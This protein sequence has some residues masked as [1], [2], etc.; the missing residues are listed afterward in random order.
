MTAIARGGWLLC[1]AFFAAILSSILYVDHVGPTAWLLL[2]LVAAAA[3]LSPAAG[4][5]I[6]AAATPV[7]WFLASQV[8]NASVAWPE[9]IVCAVLA[10]ASLN[11]VRGRGTKE[12]LPLSISAPAVLFGA[13]V[14]ASLVASLSLKALRLG[15]GFTDA[16]ITQLTREYFIDVRGFPGL[17]AGVL[18]LEGALLFAVSARVAAESKAGQV[19]LR[20]AAAYATA[21]ATLAAA[22]NIRRLVISAARGDSFWASLIDLADRLRFNVHYADFNAAGS[23]FAMAVLLAAALAVSAHGRRRI[24]W[25]LCALTIAV[26]LWLTSSRV[27]VLAVLLAPGAVLLLVEISRGRAR[28]MRAAAVAAAAVVLLACVVVMLPQ[29]GTQAS[30]LLSADVRLGLMQTGARMLASRPMFGIGLGEFSRRSGEFSSPDLIAKFPVAWNENAH[31]NYLQ[32]AAEIGLAGGILFACLIA[33]ALAVV[34]GRALVTRDEFLLLTL[35]AVGA[36]ALT[37]LG[38]HPLLIPEAGYAFWT[39]LGVAAGATAPLAPTR[40][41]RWW[42]IPAGLVAVALTLPWQLR[43]TTQ[44]ADLEHVAI[45]VSEHWQT[46]PDDRRYREATGHAALFVPAGPSKFEIYPV[47]DE[48][49][50]LELTLDGRAADILRLEP[51]RWN[52]VTLPVRAGP[53]SGRYRR[54]DLRLIDAD[55]TT[56]WITKVRPIQ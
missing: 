15:P 39:M 22:L 27:A 19:F 4:V 35:A 44:N 40:P 48:P 52:D 12:W 5:L 38:G 47:A 6:V 34:A 21:S 43:A 46:A 3:A 24:A 33:G 14:V 54:L 18:L 53:G 28:A 41:R 11:A 16:L 31:N 17:H 56:I 13:I 23:Y 2:L 32:V 30:P 55:Q 51:R 25:M 7:A 45:G 36:F 42:L 26:A 9:T 10:G 20:R 49:L 8:S 1:G 50:R 37:C 29:R